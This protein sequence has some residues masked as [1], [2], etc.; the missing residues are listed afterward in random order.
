MHTTQAFKTQ[1]LKQ[2]KVDLTDYWTSNLWDIQDDFWD[3]FRNKKRT[4]QSSL[5]DFS[6]FSSNISHEVK[7]FYMFLLENRK[8]TLT[9]AFSYG[10]VHQQLG[11]FLQKNYPYVCSFADIPAAKAKK[12]WRMYLLLQGFKSNARGEVRAN[13]YRAMF[14]GILRFYNDFDDD[15]KEFEKDFWDARKIPGARITV[16]QSN[17]QLNFT[18][19]PKVYRPLVKKYIQFRLTNKSVGQCMT[20]LIALRLFISFI[21][22]IYPEW[23]NLNLLSRKDIEDYLL[24]YR[25][26]TEGWKSCHKTYLLCL[27]L[28]IEHIQRAG[29]QEAP[30][31]PAHM[32]LWK[33]D[34]PQPPRRTE[35]DIKC[36]P[37]VFCDS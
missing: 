35:N 15:R 32:L 31:V 27:R 34:I 17:Y 5:I 13:I 12:Q 33:E 7:F 22:K 9:T 37:K 26:H 3:S 18:D 16:S 14:C 6:V 28:F 11:V 8:I 21:H 20:D 1:K 36:I 29:Y 30:N 10:Q 23:T 24:W 25:A 4:Y 2:I 19:I